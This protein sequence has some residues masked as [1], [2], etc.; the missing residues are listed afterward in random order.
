MGG[1][2]VVDLVG[3][4]GREGYPLQRDRGVAAQ[5]VVN[6]LRDGQLG[7]RRE[8]TCTKEFESLFFNSLSA[9]C[10]GEHACK[11]MS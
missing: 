9:I 6:R 2:G 11:N 7:E 10:L 4:V 8:D 3:V 5:E 1:G